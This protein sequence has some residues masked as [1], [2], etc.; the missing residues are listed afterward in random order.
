MNYG[1]NTGMQTNQPP[2]S[3]APFDGAPTQPELGK[4]PP[5]HHP[6]LPLS[7][8]ADSSIHAPSLLRT[9]I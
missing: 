3:H 7:K 5:T 2:P 9:V 6:K 4:L 1:V 8:G